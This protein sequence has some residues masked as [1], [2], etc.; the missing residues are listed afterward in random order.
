MKRT[1]G[2]LLILLSSGI[3]LLPNWLP[4]QAAA[5]WLFHLEAGPDLYRGDV[6][7]EVLGT[8]RGET[9]S[10]GG[11]IH[12][13]FSDHFLLGI[14]A[15]QGELSGSDADYIF[16][17][18][19]LERDFSFETNYW[20]ATLGIRYE[21]WI[22]RPLQPYLGLGIGAVF[23][24]PV[25]DL[26][27]NS[28]SELG[29]FIKNDSEIIVEDPTLIY[30]LS[31]GLVYQI[32][33]LIA[34]HLDF[35]YKLTSTDFLDG[36]SLSG[37]ADDNDYYG[38]LSLGMALCLGKHQAD[39]DE[40]GIPDEEDECPFKPGSSFTGGCPDS[41]N[42][43]MRDSDDQCP[44]AAGI[45]DLYGCPDT[46]Q[47]GT[48]DP[49]DRCPALAGPPESLGC[50][51]KDTDFDGIQDHLDDC[52]LEPGPPGRKGC[53]AVD[54]DQ[55]GLLDEDDN[56]PYHYGPLLF[57][58][59][60]DSDGDGIEDIKDACPASFGAFDEKGCP[61][62]SNAREEALLIN[63]QRLS[64][65][66]KN[67]NLNN[68]LLLDKLA[69]FLRNN[70]AYRV[71]IIGHADGYGSEDAFNYLSQLRAERVK[72]YLL[73]SNV[74][75]AQVLMRA[76]GARM[77]LETNATPTAQMMNRRVEFLVELR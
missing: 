22:E 24:E 43:G 1:V 21:P 4:A 39:I 8:F 16:D 55:D 72:R 36:V 19:R 60:P 61:V 47:D 7:K 68:F 54:S 20:D 6:S 33:P 44:L 53:P 28:H 3:L 13:R 35:T 49:Y 77:P 63:R 64:F 37:N 38:H 11:G 41:D 58:G 46:D 57:D 42:D 74:D 75:E 32:S 69:T 65:G 15:R 67:A 29:E 62:V 51:P 76:A 12:F 34:T 66:P 23:F 50:P 26:T 30:P 9:L 71:L 56:C 59:C 52:P 14:N 31:L 48:A 73:D 18:Y 2:F 17:S 25:A 10:W 5:K 27:N 45:P 40:D 70:P